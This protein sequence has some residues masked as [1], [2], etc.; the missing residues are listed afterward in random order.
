V[1]TTVLVMMTVD[2]AG[3]AAT[4]DVGALVSIQTVSI[5]IFLTDS[6]DTCCPLILRIHTS[7][8]HFNFIY[9]S[10]LLEALLI[11]S[12]LLSVGNLYPTTVCYG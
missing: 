1:W 3:S 4:P 9:F 7:T 12:L 11:I 2:S 8:I 5:A 6:R 10:S